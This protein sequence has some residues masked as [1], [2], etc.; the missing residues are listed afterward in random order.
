[1]LTAGVICEFDPF[2]KGHK[3]LFDEL[4]TTY[5][6]ER[7]VCVMSGDLTQ[8]GFPAGWDKFERARATVSCGAD[9]VLELPFAYSVSSADFF[10]RGGIRILKGLS[11]ID[12]LGFGSES[13]DIDALKSA[14]SSSL[15]EDG[16]F[17]EKIKAELS[18]GKSY[19]FSYG[20]SSENSV[21]S[22]PNDTLA[23]CYLR[24]NMLQE[25]GME[26]AVVKRLGG[27][28]GSAKLSERNVSATAIR[29][30]VRREG[31]LDPCRSYMPEEAYGCLKDSWFAGERAEDR[32]F[33]L[34]RQK[35]VSTPAEDLAEAPE[36][37]EGL[38]NRLKQAVASAADLDSLIKGIKSKRYSYARIARILLQIIAGITKEDIS[39]FE[40]TGCCYA[41]VLA[42][43][44]KG[45]SVLK[46][47]SDAGN[48]DI[49]SNVNKYRPDSSAKARMLAI[50]MLSA[51]LYS[52]IC[53]RPIDKYSDHI[54]VPTQIK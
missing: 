30:K 44:E 6:A 18:S 12:L 38:E 23:V 16:L 9:L 48:I 33:A 8:R 11:C 39:M 15:S 26:P 19:A 43:N 51:D 5:G 40:S 4:K 37:S 52:I 54:C 34:V 1:M 17:T 31:S 3:H 25:A 7:I 46:E 13:G 28:H 41:K 27:C 50:D 21:F 49:I 53:G 14:A 47:A 24:E 32:L 36:V 10:A 35:I 29:S 22:G 2:H 20:K 45:S 42:F